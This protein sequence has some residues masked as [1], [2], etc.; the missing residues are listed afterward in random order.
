MV[1]SERFVK[2]AGIALIAL[3]VGIGIPVLIA[4]GVSIAT[5]PMPFP[6]LLG[7]LLSVVPSMLGLLMWAWP[8]F[9]TDYFFVRGL[10]LSREERENAAQL[11]LNLAVG[12]EERQSNRKVASAVYR[13]LAQRHDGASSLFARITCAVLAPTDVIEVLGP[14][15]DDFV[16]A[17]AQ[18]V[19]QHEDR[20]ID[21]LLVLMRQNAV[22]PRTVVAYLSELKSVSAA[23]RMLREGV[24]LEYAKSL[25]RA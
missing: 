22:G 2:G 15:L 9:F 21:D 13:V 6:L 8:S 24:S 10:G 17:I 11:G 4:A 3:T 7:I 23:T 25:T 5:G 14:D 19:E 18:S 20:N 16:F 1:V 12:Y